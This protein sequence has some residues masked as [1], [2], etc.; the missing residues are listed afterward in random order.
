MQNDNRK[1]TSLYHPR[2]DV[3][4]YFDKNKSEPYYL[5][6]KYHSTTLNI[7]KQNKNIQINHAFLSSYTGDYN[8]PSQTWHNLF[9]L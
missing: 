2:F 9:R 3:F 5:N 8:F 7:N 1:N 6:Q 4:R